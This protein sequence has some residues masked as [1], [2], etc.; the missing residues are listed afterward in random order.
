VGCVS[1]FFPRSYAIPQAAAGLLDAAGVDYAL[2]GGDEWCCGFPLLANGAGDA[3]RQAILH[4]VG[5]VRALGARQVVLTCPSCYR[6]W[7]HDYPAVAGGLMDGLQVRHISE[8]LADLVDQGRLPLRA[9]GVRV[10]YHD[11]CDLGR[12]GGVV[13]APRRVLNG[14]PGLELVEMREARQD[15]LCCGGG[16]NLES[17]DPGLVQAAAARRLAQALETGAQTIVSACPQCERTLA[18]AARRQGARIRVVDLTE[19]VWEL[20]SC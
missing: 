10:T 2:L 8:L 11:P 3:A 5:R 7:A 18:Q 9:A 13:D 17:V 4:N 1:S 12:R 14:I 19:L 6:T 16:G 20:G 15:A